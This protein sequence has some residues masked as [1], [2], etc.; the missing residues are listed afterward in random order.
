[1][2][3]LS[4][5]VPQIQARVRDPAYLRS[6]PET[7]P[8]A[9]RSLRRAVR[10]APEGWALLVERKHRSP[11]SSEP[12]LPDVSLEHFDEW[13]RLGGADGLSCLAT[14]PS[15]G[16]SPREVAELVQISDKPVLFKDFVIDP[17]QIEA[18]ARTGA[19]A[20]LLIAR[21]ETG[22]FLTTPLGEL[23]SLARARGLEILLELHA[24][25][26]W[27][28]AARVSSDLVGINLRDLDSLR[29]RPEVAEETFR[30]A[31]PNHP[32]LGLSGVSSFAEAERY[33]QWGADGLLVGSSFARARDPVGF[34]RSL[35][36]P[37]PE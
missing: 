36:V 22:G 35:R 7:P 24:P 30:R 17:I 9:R 13:T 12:D 20:V 10:E 27:A 21:L 37:R 4:D 31:G 6:L 2:A 11:G 29:L 5:L 25:D 18:A 33:R 14:G 3:F 34:L 32:L 8:P 26:E 15:F 1:M 19:S 16:G 23:A 28:V